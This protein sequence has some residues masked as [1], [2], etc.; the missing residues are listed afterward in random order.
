MPSRAQLVGV[1]DQQ[2]RVLR[3]Q[4]DQQ[5]DADHAEQVERHARSSA[6]PAERADHRERQREHHGERVHEALELRG[7]HHVDHEH[8]RARARART[9]AT[10]SCI[11][12]AWPESASVTPSGRISAAICARVRDRGAELLALEVRRDRHAALAVDARDRRRRGAG[13]D[14][15]QVAQ[16]DHAR[17][18]ACA[19]R[20]CSI[21]SGS[22]AVLVLEAHADVVAAARPP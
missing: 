21:A 12:S 1:V 3:D 7:E 10:P 2:D 9:A 6:E 13:L 19:R 4:P 20:G 5:D 17:R 18:R 22:C 15:H 14:R 11:A 16:L 8:A